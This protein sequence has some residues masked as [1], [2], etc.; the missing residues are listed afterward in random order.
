MID[1]I[2]IRNTAYGTDESKIHLVEITISRCTFIYLHFANQV[3]EVT[4]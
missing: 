4:D 2:T 1:H 3:I